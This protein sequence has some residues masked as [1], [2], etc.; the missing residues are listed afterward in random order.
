[1]GDERLPHQLV[2]PG[3]SAQNVR[4]DVERLLDDD[5]VQN[6]LLSLRGGSQP[7]A[8]PPLPAQ[9]TPEAERHPE[10]SGAREHDMAAESEQAMEGGPEVRASRMCTYMSVPCMCTSPW[11]TES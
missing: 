9:A 11:C 1:M 10:D 4:K 7:G 3:G 8:G 6:L 5:E 2:P